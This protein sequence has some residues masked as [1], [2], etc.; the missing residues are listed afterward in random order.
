M[1]RPV[2]RFATRGSIVP[3]RIGDKKAHDYLAT[4]AVQMAVPFYFS[5]LPQAVRAS[6]LA[7]SPYHS[8]TGS[9]CKDVEEILLQVTLHTLYPM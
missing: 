4:W 8:I 5:A 2:T 6:F 9:M 1:Q 3:V 7:L